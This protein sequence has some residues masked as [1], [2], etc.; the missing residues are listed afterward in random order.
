[1]Y[2]ELPIYTTGLKGCFNTLYS[3]QDRYR[4][5]LLHRDI[6]VDITG[7]GFAVYPFWPLD[8]LTVICTYWCKSKYKPCGVYSMSGLEKYTAGCCYTLNW[9]ISY[10]ILTTIFMLLNTHHRTTINW[11]QVTSVLVKFSSE[12]SFGG[13][14]SCSFF[15]RELLK[16]AMIS[17]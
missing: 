4:V 10:K 3:L 1:M 2:R 7:N 8:A 13:H 14:N 15:K 9:E 16:V 6:P 5:D 12:L 11:G 17:L